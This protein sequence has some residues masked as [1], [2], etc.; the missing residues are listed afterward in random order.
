MNRLATSAATALI[1]G[2]ASVYLLPA[3]WLGHIAITAAICAAICAIIVRA[4]TETESPSNPPNGIVM[5][6]LSLPEQPLTKVKKGW[7]LTAFLTSAAFLVSLALAV[8]VR[9]NA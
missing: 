7:A 8:L 5:A 6:L 1:A 9:A 2:V 3:Q 4:G